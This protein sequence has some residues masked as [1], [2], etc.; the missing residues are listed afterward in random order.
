LHLGIFNP[1]DTGPVTGPC[2]MEAMI[3]ID[4]SMQSGSGTVLR[5]AVALVV[6]QGVPY[7]SVASTLIPVPQ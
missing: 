4:G 6:L 2:R 7:P 3:E 1:P 5:C